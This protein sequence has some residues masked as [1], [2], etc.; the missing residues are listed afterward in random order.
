MIFLN[1]VAATLEPGAASVAR[2][3]EVLKTLRENGIT[4]IVSLSPFLPGVTDTE[5]NLRG[6]LSLVEEVRPFGILCPF[7][8]LTLRDGSREH[9]YQQIEPLYPGLSQDYE[10]RYGK[11]FEVISEENEALMGILREFCK[12]RG[13]VSDQER[14]ST[15]LKGFED[16][17]AGEQLRLAFG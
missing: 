16:R 6:L 1:Y 2:R 13:I 3:V 11:K 4:T 10:K 17:F 7:I 14:L 15:Y 5:E 9:F 8:G 12:E